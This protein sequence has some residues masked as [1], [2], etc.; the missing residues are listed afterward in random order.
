MMTRLNLSRFRGDTFP[1]KCTLKDSEGNPID[2]TGAS[3]VFG[4]K[5]SAGNVV[6]IP[7][8]ILDAVNGVFHIVPT[9]VSVADI[10]T[11]PFDIQMVTQE[12]Y[13]ITL[14]N[15]TLRLSPDIVP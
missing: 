6:Q 2:I 1:I 11:F 3:I 12:G 10:G 5:D 4:Y 15:G 14:V 7:G 13:K 8:D 9:D